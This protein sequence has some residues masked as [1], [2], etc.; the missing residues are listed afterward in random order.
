MSDAAATDTLPTAD[1][2]VA[3]GLTRAEYALVCDKQARAPNQVEL[4]M[5]S[6]MWSEHCAYK[7]SRKLL[8]TL[9]TEGP[10]VLMGPGENAGAVDV[11]GGLACAFKVESHNHP[12]A[13]E[14]FQGAATGVGGILRDIFAIGARPIAVL[15]SLR[16]GEPIAAAVGASD[17]G[18]APDAPSAEDR[19]QRTRYLLDGA[20]CGI[21]HYGNSIGVPTIG[22]E[23]YFEGPYEQNCLVN[24][25]ALGLA[26]RD[27][28]VRSAAAGVGNLLVLFGASTG[29]DGIG[30]ASVLASAEL[31]DADEHKRP[32]VQVGDPFEE[33]KLLECSLQLLAQQ[34]L[35]SLQ[36]LG[37]AGLTSSASEMASKGEVGIDI[38]VAKVPL[39]EPGMAPF[40]IMVSESQERMLCVVEPA[41]LDAVLALCAKWEVNGTAIGVVTDTR[42]MRIFDGPAL[43]GNMPVDALVDDCPLYDLHPLKP[44]T[45]VYRTPAATLPA[46]APMHQTLLALVGAPNVSSRRPLFE[47]YDSIV[48]SRTVKRPEQADAAVL[49]LP[50]GSAL[51]VSI[52]CN[53]RRV[54]ADPY[55]GT[56]EAALE[57]AA[58]LA[59]VGAEPLGTTNNLNFGNPEKPHI[60]WQLTE[61]VRALGD[62]CRALRAPIVGGNVS[63]YNESPSAGPI[64]PTPVIGM[65]GRLPDATRAGHLGFAHTGD[66]VALVGWTAPPSLAA[67]ELA[68]LHGTPLPD[69][70]P[71]IDLHQ[72]IATQSAIRTAVRAGTLSSAHDI[73]EGG[74]AVALAEC[75][76]AGDLGATI[77]LS[78][79]DAPA[80]TRLFGELPGGFIVSGPRAAIDA[81]AAHAHVDVLGTVGSHGHRHD[82]G[83]GPGPG[84]GSGSRPGSDSDSGSGHGHGQELSITV[85]GAHAITV[86]LA[87]LSDAHSALAVLFP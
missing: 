22:G 52:D 37:A 11:G 77:E 50:D 87:E 84:S 39:R 73:A 34:L 19:A 48:Q 64:Y 53:G 25:M 14:P 16:F 59:C 26:E 65:V 70:L 54:A 7:H 13:V 75:C 2:A 49:A 43:V 51:G 36:D 29:R 85:D 72:V 17:A 31:G 76:L 41:Q 82:S 30:G 81:L 47:Q 20:V 83:S 18:S 33:K 35:V 6:L 42:H 55:R 4:A 63:L 56:I 71:A 46:D 5:Y 32:T 80:L 8:R 10:H 66:T 62:A 15:D 68:K 12:S 74:L 79:A 1:D 27:Q 58:N 61:S 57:C 67:S 28:L 38:D 86:T 23:L 78:A 60:A 45:P 9:P 3:L 21:G 44:T 40:E 69:E 24:A